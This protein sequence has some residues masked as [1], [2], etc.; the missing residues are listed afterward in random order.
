MDTITLPGAKITTLKLG[1]GN[2]SPVVM[3]H[4]LISGSMVSWYFT[5]AAPLATQRE[6]VLYDLRGHGG[7][8]NPLPGDGTSFSLDGQVDD[9]LAVLNHH[10]LGE[11]AIDVVGHSMGAL[12]AL[13]F[14]L[15]YPQR[16]RRLV[17]VDA[18]MPAGHY[19]GPSLEGLTTHEQVSHYVATQANEKGWVRRRDRLHKRLVSLLLESSLM[20]DIL[21]MGPEPDEALAGLN[22]S[23]LLVYGKDSPCLA[24]GHH[25]HRL[26][27]NSELVL[28]DCGHYVLVD[29]SA[30][31]CGEL[32]RFLSKDPPS[33]SIDRGQ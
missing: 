20:S 19:I 10:G 8:S 25:L 12:I 28:L 32:S 7:S 16:V 13:R 14:A 2:G 11:T 26:I 30:A 9:L 24:A 23:V 3:L 17:I 33:S 1:H 4:G 27:P 22:K 6:V 18:P 5:I 21:A 29:A 15:R 31:L